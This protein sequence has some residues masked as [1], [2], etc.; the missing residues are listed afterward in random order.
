MRYWKTY[1]KY[2][3]FIILGTL[4]FIYLVILIDDIN[5]TRIRLLKE[6]GKLP[7]PR[8]KVKQYFEEKPEDIDYDK[9]SVVPLEETEIYKEAL[10]S[11][12]P[13]LNDNT[14]RKDGIWVCL[15][16]WILIFYMFYRIYYKL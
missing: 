9:S 7:P 15:I 8:P 14:V 4:V 16:L 12:D 2:L 5:D 11:N 10:E 13:K 3:F 1:L 6:Q